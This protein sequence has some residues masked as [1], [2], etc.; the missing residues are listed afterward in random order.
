MPQTFYKLV[1][2]RG[3]TEAYYQLSDEDKATLWQRVGDAI[4]KAGGKMATPYYNCRWANDSY[5]MF[6]TM[7]YP[8]IEAAMADTT[9][10]EEAQL[11]RYMNSETI[12]GVEAI[13]MPE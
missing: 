7:E 9:G 2:V 4:S 12:L 13:G 5:L 10:V 6:F 11:F 8:S 1:L 3:F